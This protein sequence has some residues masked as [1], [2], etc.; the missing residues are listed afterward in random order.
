MKEAF[1]KFATALSDLFGSKKMIIFVTGL[2]VAYAAKKGLE[3]SDELVAAVLGATAVLIGA[4][5]AQDHGKEAAKINAAAVAQ[6]ASPATDST[7][8]PT[9]KS[10]PV[11][12]SGFARFELAALL[13]FVSIGAVLVPL[14]ACVHARAAGAELASSVIDCTTQNAKSLTQ[15]FGPALE[16]LIVRSIGGDGKVD[17]EGL[18]DATK[19]FGLQTGFCVLENVTTKIISELASPEAPKSSPIDASQLKAA[20]TALGDKRFPGVRFKTTAP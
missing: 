4:F 20:V 7:E 3:V 14:M 8:R 12:P 6:M 9:P 19:S 13:M 5:G 16:Q 1:A 15:Q 10:T 18:A 2:I 11:Q 17:T